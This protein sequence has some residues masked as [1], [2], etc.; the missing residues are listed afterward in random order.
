VPTIPVRGIMKS[1][2]ARISTVPNNFIAVSEMP[3]VAA[4][5]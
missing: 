1:T 2:N 5:M 4:A 3:K